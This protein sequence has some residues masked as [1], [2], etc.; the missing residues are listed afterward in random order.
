[1]DSIFA[2]GVSATRNVYFRDTLS[3]ALYHRSIRTVSFMEVSEKEGLTLY[4]KSGI[5]VL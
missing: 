4:R 5:V 1:V 3:A 2:G